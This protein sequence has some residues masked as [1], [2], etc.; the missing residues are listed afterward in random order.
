MCSQN[1]IKKTFS[2][3]EL[4]TSARVARL[5]GNF[6]SLANQVDASLVLT[7]PAILTDSFNGHFALHYDKHFAGIH[8]LVASYALSFPGFGNYA[9]HMQYLNYGKMSS[10]DEFGQ[11]NGEFFAYDMAV[12]LSW[13]RWFT[14]SLSLG[15]NI[16]YTYSALFTKLSHGLGVDVSVIYTSKDKLWSTAF[17]VKNAGIQFKPYV[18]KSYEPFPLDVQVAT[19][20]RL[21]GSPFGL[22]LVYHHLHKWDVF[23]FDSSRVSIDP[24]TKEPNYPGNF[25]RIFNTFLRHLI[26]G[27]DI[28]IGK[29]ISAGI[30]YNFQRR[31]E[32]SYPS[33]R[34]LVGL[35]YGIALH[36]RRFIISYS[37]NSY[38]PGISPNMFTFSSPLGNWK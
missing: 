33:R 21:Q 28:F 4:P 13:G 7:N 38:Y 5:G 8:Y 30:G 31:L 1:G 27:S 9:L 20:K 15:A 34:A 26:V 23:Y 2:F 18:S 37:R 19:Y 3:L 12:S 16:K 22:S 10:I 29:F 32:L 36:T 14:P 24:V 6:I 17:V 25:S 35:T 11:R